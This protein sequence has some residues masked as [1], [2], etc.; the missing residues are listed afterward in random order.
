MLGIGKLAVSDLS[1]DERNDLVVEVR[2]RV[3]KSRCSGCG[4]VA[5]RYDRQPAR[6]WRH[7]W[8]GRLGVWLRYQPWR[9]ECRR[10]GVRVERVPWGDGRFTSD[11]EELAAY[12][13]QSTDR[14]RVSRL[15][16]ISWRA[17]GSIIQRV[18]ERKRDP[19]LLAG[20]HRIGVD[21]F[22][23][24]KR[25]RYLTIV[26][27]HDRRRVVWA[28]EGRSSETLGQF[29]ALLTKAQRRQ[30]RYVTMD[31][32]AGYIEAVRAHLPKAEIVFDRFHVQQL[33]SNAVD[34]VRRQ[35]VRELRGT[36][37]AKKVK[38]LRFTLLKGDWRLEPEDRRRLA[39]LQKTNKPLFRAYLLKELLAE[40]LECPQPDEAEEML[41]SWLSWA[42][43]SRLEPFRRLAR[44]VRKHLDGI[45]AYVR[46]RL[47]NGLVEGLN[48]RLRMIARR[49]FGFHSAE[50][51]IAMLFLTCSGIEL[52]PPLPISANS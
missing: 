30:I 17:V 4:R 6:R 49:A 36:A 11:F 52:E 7:L 19:K 48:L 38:N 39:S 20:L 27:D 15:L 31:M 21:E 14:T 45:L 12:L 37:Q 23:Y 8:Y 40:A 43:R 3:R 9:V 32:A 29:F 47:T 42:A 51:L 2:P 46:T 44:T 18:V 16:G 13:A 5:S 25:H 33:A 1:F 28:A 41:R 50:A 34:E 26:V 22:S 24:R 10:C 35:V